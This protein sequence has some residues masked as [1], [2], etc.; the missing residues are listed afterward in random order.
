MW[1]KN[2][3]CIGTGN[4]IIC[5]VAHAADICHDAMPDGGSTC[6]TSH[7]VHR[8]VIEVSSPNSYHNSPGRNT[9]PIVR[10]DLVGTDHL[11]QGDTG[12]TKRE[13]RVVILVLA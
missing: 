6:N 4:A 7:I 10:K 12:C 9:Y 11:D 8:R 13:R 3:V 5:G 2:K 1:L